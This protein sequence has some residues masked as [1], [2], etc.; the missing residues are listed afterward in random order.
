MNNTTLFMIIFS[1]LTFWR[2]M[3]QYVFKTDI[4]IF[5]AML[6]VFYISMDLSMKVGEK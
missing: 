3:E 4:V 2:V 5:I 1:I 6:L